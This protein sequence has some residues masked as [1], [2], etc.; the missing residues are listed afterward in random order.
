MTRA[1]GREPRSVAERRADPRATHHERTPAQH[2]GATRRAGRDDA[3]RPRGAHR[4]G[5]A[6]R[7]RARRREPCRAAGRQSAPPHDVGVPRGGVP[8]RGGSDGGP[9]P[10]GGARRGLP[11]PRPRGLPRRGPFAAPRRAGGPARRG[12]PASTGVLGDHH[13]S[14][15]G[16]L[17]G[18]PDGQGRGWRR[19]GGAARGA[20][21]GLGSARLRGARPPGLV[22]LAGLGLP[23]RAPPA[24]RR[25]A[26]RHV[27]GPDRGRTGQ[28]AAHGGGLLHGVGEARARG[29]EGPDQRGAPRPGARPRAA[30]PG[31][32]LPPEHRARVAARAASG[33]LTRSAAR[34]RPRHDVFA[35]KPL[36]ATSRR[37]TSWSS[38]STSNAGPSQRTANTPWSS[39]AR[40]RSPV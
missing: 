2:P 31:G 23:L 13:R 34:R 40:S 24:R 25:G 36:C 32:D 26:L 33:R 10:S 7:G 5:G 11:V 3:R 14:R 28:C 38:R 27:G 6:R 12:G 15:G 39:Q 30:H 17:G 8:G 22:G 4:R 18:K 9:G 20:S 35:R 21:R 29:R 16:D 19:G 1:V 37:S